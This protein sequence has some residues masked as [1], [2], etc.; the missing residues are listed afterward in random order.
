M[1]GQLFNG[2]IR[3]FQQGL[4]A[5]GIAR[6][7]GLCGIKG[8]ASVDINSPPI[9]RPSW[10][11]DA[12]LVQGLQDAE[13]R[14]WNSINGAFDSMSSLTSDSEQVYECFDEFRYQLGSVVI[15]VQ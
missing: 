2:V 9:P 4:M 15:F 6:Q 11:D 5:G 13:T 1:K 12:N 3:S 8:T 7:L 14:L 10:C